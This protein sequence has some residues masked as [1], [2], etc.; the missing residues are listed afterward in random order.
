M[1][2]FH[3]PV[4]HC[5]SEIFAKKVL[6]KVLILTEPKKISCRKTCIELCYNLSTNLKSKANRNMCYVFDNSPF[7]L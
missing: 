1:E 2:L 6:K 4:M 7:A 5:N 3:F